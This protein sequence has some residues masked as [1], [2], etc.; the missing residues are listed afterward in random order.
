MEARD[1][2]EKEDKSIH[3]TSVE[4]PIRTMEKKNGNLDFFGSAIESIMAEWQASYV[5]D[6]AIHD[7]VGNAYFLKYLALS[8]IAAFLVEP[9]HR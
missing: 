2:C 1:Q 9:A 3:D 5:T 4:D 6:P 8:K 7:D